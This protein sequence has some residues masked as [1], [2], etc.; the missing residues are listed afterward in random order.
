MECCESPSEQRK[1]KRFI[2]GVKIHYNK[3]HCTRTTKFTLIKKENRYILLLLLFSFYKIYSRALFFS[4]EYFLASVRLKNINTK[5][6][7]I[8]FTMC[9]CHHIIVLL[10]RKRER[11]KKIV[12]AN[13]VV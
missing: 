4:M 7:F 13:D 11:I 3:E 8:V 5:N 1:H 2:L 6:T 9:H 12:K 10:F